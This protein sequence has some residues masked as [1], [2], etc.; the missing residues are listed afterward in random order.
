MSAAPHRDYSLVGPEAEKAVAAGLASAKWYSA[1]DPARRT[2]GADAARRWPAIRDTLIWFA[3]FIVSGGLGYYFWGTLGG[4]AVLPRLRRALRLVAD[5]RWHECGHGTA[6]KTRW[7]NDV[8]YQIACFMVLREPT[9]GAGA[10]PATT[11]TPSSSAATRRSSCRGRRTSWHCCSTS[12]AQERSSA[13]FRKVF[14]HAAGRLTEEETTFIPETERAEGLSGSRASG[15][16]STLL[17]ARRLRL[18]PARSC[19]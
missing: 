3:A 18:R 1:A 19:R 5:C 12:S 8:V 16:R 7:M 2:Q 4:G 9:S 17:V 14:L 15:W 13:A 6:F 10:I 11:P